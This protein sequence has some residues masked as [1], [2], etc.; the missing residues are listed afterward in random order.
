[1]AATKGWFE[2]DRAGLA[3]VARRRG[4]EF[5]VT[6]P[7]QNSW[8]ENT[9]LV[10]VT[11][12]AV[13]GKAKVE[14]TV[15]DDSPE[16]F[17]DMADSYMM[18]RSS[19]KLSDPEKR[20][21]FNIGEKLL[22]SVADDARI[23][24]TTGSVI[25]GPDGRTTSRKRTEVGSILTATLRMTRT[26]LE[27]AL[28]LART[29]IP[30]AGI[31]TV[32]NG[33][34][35]PDRT[36][37][38]Q[39]ERALETEILGDE[40]GFKYTRRKTAVRIYEVLTGEE[41]HLY[42]MGIPVDQIECPWHVE[43]AQKIPLSMDR[44]SVRHGFRQQVQRAAAEI[45][46]QQMQ[47]EHARGGW[48]ST[49]LEF[50]DD[51]DAV[52]AIVEKRF[53]KAVIY[54]PSSPESNKLAMDAG[55]TVVHG[56]ELSKHAWNTIRGAGAI[57]PAGRVFNDGRVRSS[58]DGIPPVPYGEWSEAMHKTAEY[59]GRFAEHTL[60]HGMEVAFYDHRDLD[61]AAFCG[62][63][64]IA[65]NLGRSHVGSAVRD[66]DQE[67]I[68]AL[69]IHECAHDKVSDHLTH[70]YHDEC[71]RIGAKARSLRERLTV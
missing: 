24:S 43:V 63:R 38:A 20:G 16:G 58:S 65:F 27:G 2:V 28:A 52:R 40:G 39:G 33:E 42:E 1:M 55:Y 9:T 6:E 29:L 13:P 54:D 51:E 48:V 44:G 34:V 10:E 70:E 53:G 19:Y 47:E 12:V 7:I 62:L 37:L 32:I 22:L 56:G 49:A 31:V 46:A 30:P 57:Q 69:L 11:M 23:T 8:D 59:A 67:A 36:P 15:K 14:L 17:R 41:A 60:G 35:L 26:E 18:F 3:E 25:F 68:D 64:L 45:M 5:I 66:G 71:C 21:R 50:M 61:F 4:M